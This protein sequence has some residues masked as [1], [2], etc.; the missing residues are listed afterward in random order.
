MSHAAPSSLSILAVPQP[1]TTASHPRP[2]VSVVIVTHDDG[3]ALAT[4]VASALR[5]TVEPLE[6]I[7]VDRASAVDPG[8]MLQA[9]FDGAVRYIRHHNDPVPGPAPGYNVGIE[10]SRGELVQLLDGDD[11]LAPDKLE[12][13]LRAMAADP[14]LDIAYGD[15]RSFLGE[16]GAALIAD[17]PAADP[18]DMLAALCDGAGNVPSL[19]P[20]SALF[21]R[22]TLE[23]VGRFDE[24]ILSPDY[25]YWFRAAWDGCRFRFVRESLVFYRR[26]PGQMSADSIAMLESSI[27]TLEKA[28]GFIV[29]DRYRTPLLKRLA[30]LYISRVLH[31][32]NGL[33]PLE[34]GETLARAQRAGAPA[35]RLLAAR[36]AV[37]VPGLRTVLDGARRGTRRLRGR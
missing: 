35:G 30:G 22:K 33:T 5:Q 17:R 18:P 31:P 29:D 16:P 6:V 7:V 34:V 13:Q 14:E 12:H 25:D 9:R 3:P 20:G 36:A 21:R 19:F 10:A 26:S 2:T 15:T 28:V 32:R 8:P 27:V 4:A 24:Q 11:C 37:K 23:R 1:P